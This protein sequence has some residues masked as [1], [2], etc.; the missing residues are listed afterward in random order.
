MAGALGPGELEALRASGLLRAEG[1]DPFEEVS[2]PDL[3]R[4][5]RAIYGLRS[6]GMTLPV[7]FDSQP[8]L[9]G[10]MG[11]GA[12]QRDVLLVIGPAGHLGQ[13]LTRG[14]RSLVLAPTARLVTPEMR[15]K[16]AAGAFVALEVLAE[17]LAV[18]DGRLA[19]AGVL[20]P[21]APDLALSTPAPP[22]ASPRA[23]APAPASARAPTA[24]PALAPAPAPSSHRIPG[25]PR[26]NAIQVTLLDERTVRIDLPGVSVRRTYVDLGMAHARTREPT[27]PWL[28]LVE[29][30]DGYGTFRSHAFGDAAATKK[31]VSRLGVAL[32]DVFGLRDSPFHPYRPRE[33]WRTKFQASR[34]ASD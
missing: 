30:C 13:A 1:D 16:H 21:A 3:V 5:L 22:T 9:L 19:R 12:E 29:L 25:A 20:A 28:L 26:W 34:K 2:L 15:A 27:R 32:R 17:S 6:R 14:G 4:T 8:V 10:K 24:A 7:R 31:L 23:P 11:D 18:R 33:G